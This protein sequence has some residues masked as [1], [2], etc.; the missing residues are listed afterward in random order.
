MGY[1]TWFLSYL[2]RHKFLTLITILGVVVAIFLRT[3]IPILVGNL[4]IDQ[5]ILNVNNTYSGKEQQLAALIEYVAVII[6][7]SVIAA[8]FT[9]INVFTNSY[10]AWSIDRDIRDDFFDNIQSKPL[11][12]HDK[13]RTGEIMALATNDINQIN[14]MASFGVRLSAD[15]F[16]TLAI[17]AF[18]ALAGQV[19]LILTL[20]AICFLPFYLWT[21]NIYGKRLGPISAVFNRRYASMS[22]A[23][24]D[25]LEGV[26][27]VR[28]FGAED[29]E[30]EKFRRVIIEFRDTWEKRQ[31]IMAKYYPSFVLYAVIGL[32]VVFGMFL[33]TQGIITLGSMI[34]FNGLLLTLIFPTLS[35]SFAIQLVQAGFAGASRIYNT[36]FSTKGEE[37]KEERLGKIPW[38]GSSK[39]ALRG[40]VKFDHVWF[41]Y[42]KNRPLLQRNFVFKD[43]SFKVNPGET[44]AIVGPTG[45][46]KTSL[47]NLLLR[48]YEVDNGTIFIDGIDIQKF[49]LEDLRKN[50]GRI[51]QDVFLYATTIKRNIA[52]GKSDATDEEIQHVAKLA[53]AHDFIMDLENGYDTEVGERGVRLSGGQRQRIAIA[54]TFLTDP[55]ILILD[56]STSSIDSQTEEQIIQAI[57]ALLRG[58][59]AFII[60]HRLSTIRKADKIIVLKD[61]GI[62]AM[63]TH[64]ELIHTSR[65]YRRIYGKRMDLPPLA[66]SV[67]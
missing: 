9:F 19:D 59:T 54:R 15:V 33:V 16:L 40:E 20:F 31:F 12:F 3:L 49:T 17:V 11:T 37:S 13:T 23:L 62:V 64:D 60:T 66:V 44:V 45:S 52:F 41:S 38:P 51:E 14:G 58:R 8:I 24:Q 28:A 36:M 47:T 43:I 18:L 50:L 10:V 55:K 42:G 5:V 26:S 48:L 4:I 61:G 2:L 27:V 53:Q 63:G 7:I 32:S 30:R 35:I 67:T 57:D 65:A 21:I 6:V 29:F 22:A 1:R 56:D 39:H 34:A 25:N 46:G